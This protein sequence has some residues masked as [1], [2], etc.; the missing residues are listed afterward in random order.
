MGKSWWRESDAAYAGVMCQYDPECPVHRHRPG[1]TCPVVYRKRRAAIRAK[2]QRKVMWFS[3]T[4]NVIIV[5][6]LAAI[7]MHPELLD[8][9]GDWLAWL[10]P[11]MFGPT[12]GQ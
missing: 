5:V 7:H 1:T 8:A 11:S 2:Q 6:F 4:V 9:I 12:A 10:W 3:I